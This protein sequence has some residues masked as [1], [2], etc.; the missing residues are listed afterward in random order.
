VIEYTKISHYREFT[1]AGTALELDTY[2]IDDLISR[3]TAQ[4]S[5][6]FRVFKMVFDLTCALIGVLIVA[7]L[8]P[9]LIL[10]N[11][12]LNPGPLFFSQERIGLHAKP[13]RM[14]K[15]RTMSVSDTA[16]RDP[17]APL[18]HDRITR[19][20]RLMR[21][22]RIDELPNFFN[23]LMGEM[24]VVGPRPDASN[25]VDLYSE[26]VAGYIHRHRVR[27]G[28]TGLAQ[29]KQG[30]VEDADATEIKAKYDNIYVTRSCGRLD[31]Y[32]ILTTFQVLFR[33][34]GAR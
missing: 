1:S 29:V 22:Y 17:N 4:W 9:L 5:L 34:F 16:A 30:Y 24:S 2:H 3:N 28:I 25:H 8:S 20:G 14:W 13:F 33:G 6:K 19:L 18:E 32:I 26:S 12:F 15:F 31:V 27:P 10:V 11:P 7:V 21:R 23:V